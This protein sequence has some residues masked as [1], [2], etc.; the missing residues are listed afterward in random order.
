MLKPIGFGAP[1]P[2]A[3]RRSWFADVNGANVAAGMT[4]GLFYAFG[5]IPIHLDAMASLRLSS[6]AAVSWFF[7]TFMTS[8]LGSV[9]LTMRYRLPLPIGWSIPALVFLVGTG[10]RYSHA[11][12]AGAC[13]VAGVVIVA[14]GLLGVGEHLMRWLPLPIVMGMFAGNVLGT[15]SGAFKH[16]E[17]QPWVVGAAI[18]GYLGARLVGRSWYPPMAGAFV[19]GLI[20]SAATAQ[21]RPDAFAWSA[22]WSPRSGRSSIPSASSPSRR[23]SS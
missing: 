16:L 7:V 1:F 18:A 3:E 5:A 17:T 15:V 2:R 9:F 19:A 10:D 22:P 4:A 8:A 20:V 21:V 12:M 14:V 13:L 23:R 6:R 11:E